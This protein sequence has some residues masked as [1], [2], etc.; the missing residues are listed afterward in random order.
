MKR[1]LTTQDVTW[2]LDV[3]G[4]GRLDLEPSYQRKSVWTRGD[5]EYF[6]DTIFNNYPS[7]AI[8]LHK[9]TDLNGSTTYHVVDGKQRLETILLFVQNKLAIPETISD[10][11]L[12]NKRWKDLKDDAD[13]KRRLWDYEFTVEMLDTIE[14]AVVNDVFGRLNKNSRK[15]TPQEIRHSRFDGW[16]VTFAEEQASRPIWSALKVSTTA[17]ARRMQDVQFISELMAVVLRQ[18]LQ[19]FDQD[20]LDALYAEFEDPADDTFV[21][22]DF[23]SAFEAGLDYI[24]EAEQER[25]VVSTHARTFANIYTLWSWV[26]LESGDTEP[27]SFAE[28][29]V[30]FMTAATAF[31]ETAEI[32]ADLESLREPIERYV[33]NSRGASTDLRQREERSISLSV[34]IAHFLK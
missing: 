7:P 24:Q 33:A 19:G 17:R 6:L 3:N 5:R 10:N 11:R 26:I 32:A 22:S 31:S 4:A 9:D 34:A 2:F 28:A 12:A 21:L 25:Q 15:L 13:L 18:S 1:R 16:F 14:P 30:K 27:S 20:A 8:F 29:Y 23:V